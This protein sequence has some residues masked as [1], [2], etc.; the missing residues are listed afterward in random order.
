MC[1]SHNLITPYGPVEGLVLNYRGETT[2]T[3]DIGGKN[4]NEN[5]ELTSLVPP[6]SSPVTAPKVP[7][8]PSQ[9]DPADTAKLCLTQ[10]K[11][12][13]KKSSISI[14]SSVTARR[15]WSIF[16]K[17]PHMLPKHL[18]IAR[19]GAVDCPPLRDWQRGTGKWLCRGETGPPVERPRPSF[20]RFKP[21]PPQ[22]IKIKPV[23]LLWKELRRINAAPKR[24]AAFPR[25]SALPS[26]CGSFGFAQTWSRFELVPL[27]SGLAPSEVKD[28]LSPL[29]LR[30]QWLSGRILFDCQGDTSDR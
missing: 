3:T 11:K 22:I 10:G 13:N 9:W 21:P 19:W 25:R 20:K 4:R 7:P 8:P 30:C 5:V 6:C 2:Y 14:R 18:I 26:V 16:S 12:K 23:H 28:R 29:C 24:G 1:F 15:S 17:C 27:L